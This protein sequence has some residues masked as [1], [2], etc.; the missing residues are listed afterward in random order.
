MTITSGRPITGLLASSGRPVPMPDASSDVRSVLLHRDP[1][2]RARTLAVEFPSGFTRPVAGRYQVGEE[3]VV[4]AGEL[5]LT[6]LP[7][8]AG[9]WAWLPAGL[10]RED[11]SSPGGCLVLAWFS[12]P[13]DW[14]RAPREHRQGPPA[15]TEPLGTRPRPLR[16]GA[17]GDGPGRSAL[18]AAGAEVTGPAE[19]LSLA[20]SGWR[21]L[22]AGQRQA[23]GPGLAF[24]RWHGPAGAGDG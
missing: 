20:D 16:G 3:V 13:A 11:F 14:Q 23:A 6:R 19:L 12:G 4:L 2:T 9:D 1:V 18:V 22:P 21:W 10:L 17:A 8:A 5:R 24:A 15:R 7:L